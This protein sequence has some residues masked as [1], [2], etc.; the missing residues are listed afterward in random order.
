V[1][2]RGQHLNRPPIS[3]AHIVVTDPTLCESLAVAEGNGSP[4][5]YAVRS[6]RFWFFADLPLLEVDELGHFLVLCDQLHD[7][8]DQKHASRRTAFLAITG[9]TPGSD[10]PKL[11]ELTGYLRDVSVPFAISV[12]PFTAY[13][14]GG[15]E[16]RLTSR[17][18][19]ARVL[20]A[21]QGEGAAILVQMPSDQGPTLSEREEG[22]GTAEGPLGQFEAAAAALAKCGLFPLGVTT[23]GGPLDGETSGRCSTVWERRL[24]AAPPPALP[25]LPFLR[26][27]HDGPRQ[28]I[29]DNLSALSGE[30]T[31]PEPVLEQVRL[32]NVVSDPWASIALD[33][34]APIQ[35][36]Q[37]LLAALR[38]MDYRFADLR[39][40]ANHLKTDSLQV[41]S[42]A[43]PAPL[44]DLTPE[45]WNATLVGPGPQEMKRF[46]RPPRDGRR[47]ALLRPGAILIAYPPGVRAARSFALGGSPHE[48]AQRLVATIA[49]LAVFFAVCASVVLVIIYLVQVSLQRRT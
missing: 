49:R 25:A 42:A 31:T 34:E 3:L 26:M 48:S 20:R 2:Y 4:V 41:A 14:E 18:A 33:P 11:R 37:P 24:A 30:A 44:T 43:A 28:V 46:E 38:D 36:V 40:M 29:P 8:L 6:G 7:I 45:G 32:L 21:A 35:A 27:S 5:P 10:P 39:R 16:D 13:P 23:A 15:T 1:S 17:S 9:V 47:E 22:G 12:L 19:L